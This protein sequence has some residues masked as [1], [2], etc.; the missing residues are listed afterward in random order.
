M[1]VILPFVSPF[2]IS[3]RF[4]VH[5]VFPEPP[6]LLLLLLIPFHILLPP[7]GSRLQV[8]PTAVNHTT[9]VSFF[10]IP[11]V[12][13]ALKK[14]TTLRGCCVNALSLT[15]LVFIHQNSVHS[16]KCKHIVF[17]YSAD[18]KSGY[19]IKH[20]QNLQFQRY[21]HWCKFKDFFLLIS[22]SI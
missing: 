19:Q 7:S 22:S 9:R 4:S 10:L 6:T 1:K 18:I 2:S 13:R 21:F 8:P 17:T 12:N 15:S 5:R 16:N 3:F 14:L 20:L 11:S